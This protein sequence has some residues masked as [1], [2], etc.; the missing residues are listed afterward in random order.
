MQERL[1]REFQSLGLPETNWLGFMDA[2]R[3]WIRCENLP[4]N[5]ELQIS[6]LRLA[7]GW[8]QL[9][10]LNQDLE[11]PADYVLADKDCHQE[12]LQ[13]V[14]DGNDP[15]IVLTAGPGMGKSTYLSY[16]VNSLHQ[17][18]C[19]VVRHH[20]SLGPGRDRLER[21]ESHRIAESLM[22]DLQIELQPYLPALDTQNPN[23]AQDLRI[24][25]ERSV[26]GCQQ[27]VNTWS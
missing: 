19:H 11:V 16:L 4:P 5:G 18:D 17:S 13:R 22:A 26:K 3:S 7:C 21:V 25:L 10:P 14:I 9:S 27:R 24:W 20:Y 12:L 8:T 2:I 23:P 1:Q 15:V 6:N